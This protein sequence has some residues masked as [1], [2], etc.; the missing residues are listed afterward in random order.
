MPIEEI[1]TA[2]ISYLIGSFPTAYVFGKKK[3]NK[4]IRRV[5]TKNMGAL[6]VYRS[7]GKFYGFLTFTIDSIKG[8]LPILIAFRLQFNQWWAGICGLMAIIGHNWSI[9]LKFKGGKGGSTSIGMIATL[10]PA[11]LPITLFVFSI[12][13]FFSRNISLC[14]GFCFGLLP[15]IT[16]LY[17]EST[18]LIIISALIP[19]IALIRVIPGMIDMIN[20]SERSPKNM[21]K[22]IVKGFNKF[23]EENIT[24]KKGEKECL[25]QR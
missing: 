3:M 12:I 22:I 1:F 14:L 15:L 7:I 4:D 18:T 19:T 17:S 10:F 23:E 11:E 24:K 16:Y 8:A 9:Y 6:N 5:G 13:Y 25:S 21:L 20:L 2:I